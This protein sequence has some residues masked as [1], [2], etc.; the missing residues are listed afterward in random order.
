[1]IGDTGCAERRGV[2]QPAVAFLSQPAG[3]EGF[4]LP[5]QR[6]LR[7]VRSVWRCMLRGVRPT[8][9]QQAGCE[10]RQQAAAVHGLAASLTTL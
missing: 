7:C 8:H 3:G 5:K 2:L 4:D 1:M 10:E 9:R 6:Y